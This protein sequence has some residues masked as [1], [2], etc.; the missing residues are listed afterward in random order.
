MN[1]F[2]GFQQKILDKFYRGLIFAGII[3]IEY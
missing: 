2:N 3:N 1:I